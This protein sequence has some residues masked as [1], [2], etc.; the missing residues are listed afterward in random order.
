[1][2]KRG[3]SRV[4]KPYW[5][6]THSLPTGIWN[7]AGQAPQRPHVPIDLRLPPV[8]S[9]RH[10]SLDLL[11]PGGKLHHDNPLL[12]YSLFILALT[13]TQ[14]LS[15]VSP[16]GSSPHPGSFQSHISPITITHWSPAI[17]VLPLPSNQTR[18]SNMW[19]N[20]ALAAE[21]SHQAYY[22]AVLGIVLGSLITLTILILLMTDLF[23]R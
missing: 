4:W 14:I 8:F 18:H 15:F 20:R 7:F 12:L 10:C 16:V 1:M 5:T 17:P 13:L 9:N 6:V 22:I 19:N 23:A 11:H 3:D 2:K 21:T